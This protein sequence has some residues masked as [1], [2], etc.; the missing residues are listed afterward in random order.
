M[1]RFFVVTQGAVDVL[2]DTGDEVSYRYRKDR[3][4]GT[5][6]ISSASLS[7]STLRAATDETHGTK[8]VAIPMELYDDIAAETGLTSEHI[9]LLVAEA[10]G[11]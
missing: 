1:T 3:H 6:G 11:G 10:D 5:A 4:F 9:A 8:V 7:I 2:S